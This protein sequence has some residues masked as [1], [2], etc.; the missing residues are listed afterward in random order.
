MYYAAQIVKL[1]KA[2]I[3]Y[4]QLWDVNVAEV[5]ISHGGHLNDVREFKVAFV[6]KLLDRGFHENF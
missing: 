3:Y 2:Y 5:F 6:R 1:P 4:Q